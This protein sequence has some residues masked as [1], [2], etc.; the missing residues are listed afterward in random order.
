MTNCCLGYLHDRQDG[1]Q[2]ALC[3]CV[4]GRGPRQGSGLRFRQQ[5][6]AQLHRPHREGVQGGPHPDHGDHEEVGRR[7]RCGPLL[8]PPGD[9]GHLHGPPRGGDK[10]PGERAGIPQE[11]LLQQS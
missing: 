2:G 1:F 7:H 6:D 5:R 9:Q 8:R 10:A 3:G 4:Q 11:R